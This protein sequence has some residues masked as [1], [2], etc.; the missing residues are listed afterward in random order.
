MTRGALYQE[1]CDPIQID[2][3][4]ISGLEVSFTKLMS[5]TEIVSLLSFPL[6]IYTTILTECKCFLNSKE[7]KGPN[8]TD[9]ILCD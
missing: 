9:V 4:A 3:A 6:A 8:N 5:W 7:L 2:M 1:K